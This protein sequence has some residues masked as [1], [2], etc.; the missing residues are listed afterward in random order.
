[1]K[2]ITISLLSR[3]VINIIQISKDDSNRTIFFH[4][5]ILDL[6]FQDGKLEKSV[7]F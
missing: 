6:Q 1:M 3:N 7:R 5:S 4:F 2:N